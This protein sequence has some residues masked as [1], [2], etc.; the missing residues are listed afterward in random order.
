[1]VLHVIWNSTCNIYSLETHHTNLDLFSAIEAIALFALDGCT[2]GADLSGNHLHAEL[3]GTWPLEGPTGLHTSATYFRSDEQSYGYINNTGVLDTKYAISILVHIYPETD[4]TLVY[5]GDERNGMTLTLLNKEISFSYY[6]TDVNNVKT[7]TKVTKTINKYEQW[8][9]VAAMYDYNAQELRLS[10]NGDVSVE[11]KPRM[12]LPTDTDY[13]F[14]IDA[15]FS[16]SY[17]GRMS[18]LQIYDR[19]LDA[20]E[21]LDKEIC[22]SGVGSGVEG[23]IILVSHFL[24][25]FDGQHL[26]YRNWEMAQPRQSVQISVYCPYDWIL[27]RQWDTLA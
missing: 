11:N 5:F 19:A 20:Q 16:N 21:I 10:V 25:S 3:S 26:A 6:E 9:Y 2:E 24:V 12:E 18:C 23:R 22:P 7:E 4:G 8:Y 27:G 17:A 13:Y 1:M 14:G 15:Q